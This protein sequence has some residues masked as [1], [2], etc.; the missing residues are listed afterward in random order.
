M[1]RYQDLFGYEI[2]VSLKYVDG[3]QN[4]SRKYK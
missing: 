4:G 2:F 1:Q 3:T